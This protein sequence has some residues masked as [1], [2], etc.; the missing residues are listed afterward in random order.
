MD[1]VAT[2]TEKHLDRGL[3]TTIRERLPAPDRLMPG[4]PPE[5]RWRPVTGDFLAENFNK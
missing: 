2:K 1:G 4:D 5:E 3:P